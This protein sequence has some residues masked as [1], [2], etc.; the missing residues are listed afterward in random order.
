MLERKNL[1]EDKNDKKVEEI[2]EKIENYKQT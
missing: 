2:S 1:I